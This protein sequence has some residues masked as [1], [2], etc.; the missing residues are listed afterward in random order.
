MPITLNGNGTVTGITVGGLPDGIVDTDMLAANAVN[1][2]KLGAT[3]GKNGPFLQVKQTVKTDVFSQSVATG[4]DS[5]V[6]TGLTVSITASSATNK[7]LIIYQVTGD[8]HCNYLTI[9]KDGSSLTNATGDA[10][11]NIARCTGK[12]DY[13]AHGYYMNSLPLIF[14]DTAGDTNA[15]TYGVKVR[16]AS[17]STQD[18]FINRRV[19]DN[20]ATNATAISTVTALE[21]A[22]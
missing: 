22:A 5:S 1:L 8:I 6:I 13:T 17:L 10:S 11:G 18:V 4:T 15:H 16:H 2:A 14:L 12:G 21:V 7:I 20:V 3:T 9:T 19:N